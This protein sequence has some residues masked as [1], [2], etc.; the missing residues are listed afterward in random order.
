MPSTVAVLIEYLRIDTV[1]ESLA[2]ASLEGRV[3]S[4]RPFAS[5]RGVDL[6]MPAASLCTATK[7]LGDTARRTA[8][9][10]KSSLRRRS[11]ITLV[12]RWE[13]SFR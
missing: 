7:F 3:L 1:I 9:K 12:L 13:I 2:S 8:V 10:D 6:G 5:N 11:L 4:P